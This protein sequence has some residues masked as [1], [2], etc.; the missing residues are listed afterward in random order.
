MTD[1]KSRL[2]NKQDIQILTTLSMAVL[3]DFGGNQHG[4]ELYCTA[5]GE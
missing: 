1:F 3:S 4:Y 2:E 5:I